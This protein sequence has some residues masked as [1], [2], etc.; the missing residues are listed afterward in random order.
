V[1]ALFRCSDAHVYLTVPFV[2]SWS[3]LEA[4][5]CG[6]AL[7]ASATPPVQEVIDDAGNGLL[8]DM[9]EPEAIAAAVERVLVDRALARGLRIAARHTIRDRYALS[10]QLRRQQELVGALARGK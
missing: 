3:V 5:S 4:M 9:R 1:R 2:L 7:I 8:V 10:T 6:C